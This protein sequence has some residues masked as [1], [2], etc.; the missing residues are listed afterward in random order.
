MRTIGQ[1]ASAARVG[2]ET[3]RYYERIGLLP[4]PPSLHDGWRRYPDSVL[5]TLRQ[6]RQGRQLGF[7]LAE[8][9]ELFTGGRTAS[10]ASLQAAA[11]A[12]VV[13]LDQRIEQLKLQRERLMELLGACPDAAGQADCA[14]IKQIGWVIGGNK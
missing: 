13:E 4:K 5:Q 9:A 1:L 3:V 7:R 6:I 2:V 11:Y 8:I 10:C 14:A 12:K